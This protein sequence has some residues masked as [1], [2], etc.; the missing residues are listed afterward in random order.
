MR[1]AIETEFNISPPPKKNNPNGLRSGDLGG[2]IVGPPLPVHLPGKL[3]VNFRCIQD[4][5]ESA[6]IQM[7]SSVWNETRF[8]R[9]LPQYL[10]TNAGTVP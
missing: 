1:Y 4:A 3:L 7:L 10:Q 2:H 5:C 6:D 9:S 8:D